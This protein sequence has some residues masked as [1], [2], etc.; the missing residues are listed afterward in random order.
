LRISPFFEPLRAYVE[1]LVHPS[2]RAD[3]VAA[4]RHRTF[5]ATRLVGGLVV[6][7]VLPIH[8]A[9]SGAPSMIEALIYGWMVLPV[10][11]AWYLSRTGAYERAHV[12][13]A[14]ALASLVAL[15]AGATGGINSF[16]APWIAVIPLEAMLSAS[17]RVV[18]AA[19]AIALAT[20]L[21]L[22]AT[23]VLE[24][25]PA[26]HAAFDTAELGLLGTLS[27]A[28]YAGAVAFGVC[29]LS[30]LGE[31]VALVGE[32]RYHLLAEN[33][34]DVITRHG[35][36]GAVTFVS[37]AAEQLLGVPAGELMGHRLF[38][39]VHVA[40]RPAFLHALAEAATGGKEASVEYRVRRGELAQATGR[41][42]QFIW[43]ETRC[44]AF[45]QGSR[46]Q[47]GTARAVVAVTRD[48]SDRKADALAVE[49]AR[50]DVERA[51]DAKSSFLATVSHELRTPL[52]AII[53]FAEML[54]HEREVGIDPARGKEYAAVIRD[55]GEHL[56]AVVNGILDVSRIESGNFAIHPEPFALAPL[57]ESCRDMMAL[58][59]EQAGVTLK[60]D[61]AAGL[62]ELVADKRAIRQVLLN[63]M[64]NAVKFTA[65]GGWVA[66][67]ARR[68]RGD[69]V[70][71]VTDTGIGIADA[72]LGQLGNPF[73]QARSSY[74]RPY[75]GTGLGLSVVKGLVELHRGHVE[76][77]S[78][79]GEGT[80]AQVRLPLVAVPASATPTVERL[81]ARTDLSTPDKVKRSA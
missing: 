7:A 65:R 2:V 68:E 76:F 73:F 79:L 34:T 74:D 45:D 17:R 67:V 32:A 49:A 71:S 38:E 5:I 54:A 81:P 12:L 36:N 9:L 43:V 60:L 48:I 42:P 75:E 50:A 28:L 55:S 3:P 19:V 20:A 63:L 27:A 40:D 72:D 64:C 4:A 57:I 26:E 77:S 44:H 41:E 39:R 66:I 78:R 10:L 29:T 24:L 59:A 22:W 53:G 51:N 69:I 56:L 58:R 23:G 14:A 11:V 16:A 21:G 8:L 61:V 35:R 37:P 25:L 47:P 15:I 1:A 62:P 30:R 18:A 46:G 13:S 6:F 31:R 70:F 33:M 52:N 80:S